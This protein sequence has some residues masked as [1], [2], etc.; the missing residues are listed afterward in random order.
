MTTKIAILWNV[1]RCSL[2][3]VYR[4]FR[5]FCCLH[6]QMDEL[7]YELIHPDDSRGTLKFI[8]LMK[9]VAGS[10]ETSVY[11]AGL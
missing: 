8:I 11:F 2:V 5:A 9:D 1:T 6:H 4:R 10:S 7:R 3:E